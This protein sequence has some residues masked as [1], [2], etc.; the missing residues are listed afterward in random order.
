MGSKLADL[1]RLK[2]NIFEA[3]SSRPGVSSCKLWSLYRNGL[4]LFLLGSLPKCEL[5]AIVCY[6]LGKEN[7]ADDHPVRSS[8]VDAGRALVL[9]CL[10]SCMCT[11]HLHNELVQALLQKATAPKVPLLAKVAGYVDSA[12]KDEESRRSGG[13]PGAADD[14]EE[15]EESEE[16][17][18]GSRREGLRFYEEL[19]RR[20]ARGGAV[21]DVH[22]Y[23]NLGEQP[24]LP[25]SAHA[26]SKRSSLCLPL[27]PAVGLSICAQCPRVRGLRGYPTTRPLWLPP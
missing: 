22:Q 3:I 5:D 19:R 1:P 14:G 25:L 18:E 6:T 26:G 7:G 17:S 24:V 21:W 4:R 27:G 10:M 11:V 8:Q 23:M 15:D 13:S 16:E 20:L 9:L 12:I 2:I